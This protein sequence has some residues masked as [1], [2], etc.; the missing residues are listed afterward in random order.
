[1][2]TK[3]TVPVIFEPPCMCVAYCFACICINIYYLITHFIRPFM[4]T[5]TI[6]TIVIAWSIWHILSYSFTQ[7]AYEEIIRA[8]ILRVLCT[9]NSTQGFQNRNV[10]WIPHGQHVIQ[11]R[12]P[13]A[14]FRKLLPRKISQNL[15]ERMHAA[16]TRQSGESDHRINCWYLHILPAATL[17]NFAYCHIVICKFPVILKINIDCFLRQH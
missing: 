13:C 15:H 12:R 11:N 8:K 2:V 10:N 16:S 4:F 1:M 5:V 17:R 14:C 6:N 7:L 9:C 3:K